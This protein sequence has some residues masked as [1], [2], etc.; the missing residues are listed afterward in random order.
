MHHANANN[1]HRR[2]KMHYATKLNEEL[3]EKMHLGRKKT[4]VTKEEK[5][6]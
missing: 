2:K 6:R 4:R 1:Y 5:Y 3:I